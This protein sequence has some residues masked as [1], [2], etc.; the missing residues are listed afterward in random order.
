[1]TRLLSF[2][3]L[4]EQR[5]SRVGVMAEWAEVAGEALPAIQPLLRPVAR[6]ATAYPD[7]RSPGHRLKVV[8]HGDGTVVAIDEQDWQHRRTL[9]A[10]DVVLHEL[11]L[12][13]LRGALCAA[14]SCVRIS[15]TPVE[16]AASVLQIGNWEPKKAARFPVYLLICSSRTA[17]RTVILD[18]VAAVDKPGAVLLTPTRAH[19]GDELE[20]LARSRK[21]LLVATSEVVDAV[22]GSLRETPAWEE[23]LQAFA[24][25]VNLTLPGNYRNKKPPARR[26]SL[27]AMVEK[28][29]NALVEHIRSARDGVVVNMDAG[30]GA[31][32]VKFMTKSELGRLAGLKPYQVTRC[33]NTDPQIRRLYEIAN[34][35]EQLLRYGR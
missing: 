3:R 2:W 6:C 9:T 7:E 30:N 5:P 14:L 31:R 25:M 23:Y 22:D 28:A 1:M 15:R 27:M 12:K 13:N 24:Q 20:A 26:A 8:R 17:M 34:D 29:K 35:P 19:W 18:C 33:F 10:D 32:L 4:L 16:R 11:D 21:L